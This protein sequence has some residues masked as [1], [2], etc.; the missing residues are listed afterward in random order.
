MT[1]RDD[2]SYLQTWIQFKEVEVSSL[3]TVQIFNSSSS[4]VIDTSG[5]PTGSLL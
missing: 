3:H 1:I 5:K 4:H 2:L